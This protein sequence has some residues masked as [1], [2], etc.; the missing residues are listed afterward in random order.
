MRILVTEIA[1]LAG[2]GNVRVRLGPARRQELS[3]EGLR[4]AL[5]F[6]R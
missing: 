6:G 1:R 3:G 4:R 5:R 2:I